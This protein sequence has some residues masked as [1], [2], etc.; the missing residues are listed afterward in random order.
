MLAVAV[1]AVVTVHN[2]STIKTRVTA[3]PS[4][5]HA[6]IHGEIDNVPD[7]SIGARLRLWELAVDKWLER[8]VFGWG[9]QSSNEL[10][11]QS[12]DPHIQS[13]SHFHNTYYEFVVELGLVGAALLV[14]GAIR[15]GRTLIEAWRR[16]IMPLDYALY[17]IGGIGLLMISS[18]SDFIVWA[19]T[20][21]LHFG[22]L[23]AIV[24]GYHYRLA[25][26]RAPAH[27]A[28]IHP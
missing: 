5:W 22:M 18:L 6:I 24:Y 16:H 26:G 11:K 20:W 4:A 7:G 25:A 14:I 12:N 1:A 9:P 3:E 21:K 15:I 23:T 27:R 10:I 17:A 28:P 8:P 13:F 19:T 2:W